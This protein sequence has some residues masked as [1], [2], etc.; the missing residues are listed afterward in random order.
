ML[1]TDIDIRTDVLCVYRD[2]KMTEERD[3]A[4]LWRDDHG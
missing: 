1:G 2:G 3:I 4:D